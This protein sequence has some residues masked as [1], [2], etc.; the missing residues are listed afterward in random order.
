MR[1]FIC[2]SLALLVF[3]APARA[4]LEI[5]P[6]APAGAAVKDAA[7]AGERIVFA[8]TD[9]A[10]W[11]TDGR[12]VAKLREGLDP[13]ELSSAGETAYFTG[14]DDTLH[15]TDGTAVEPIKTGIVHTSFAGLAPIGPAYVFLAR[16]V[17]DTESNT[18]WRTDGS[19]AGTR[20]LGIYTWAWLPEVAAVGET[21]LLVKTRYFLYRTDGTTAVEE[22]A[23][24]DAATIPGGFLTRGPGP[25]GR[26]ELFRLDASGTNP[27]PVAPIEAP[28]WFARLT[29]RVIFQGDTSS[30]EPRWYSTDLTG[31]DVRTLPTLQATTPPHVAAGA[32]YLIHY[33]N[34]EAVLSRTDG[35]DVVVL[36]RFATAPSGFTAFEGR[37]WFAAGELWSTDGTAAGTRVEAPAA[38]PE[39]V[40]TD[41]VL[42]FTANGRPWVV[43]D[44]TVPTPTPTP[45]PTVTA[46]ATPTP[47][48]TATATPTATAT[49][50][51]TATAAPTATPVPTPVPLPAPARPPA[52]GT[53]PRAPSSQPKPSVT[54]AVKR[55]RSVRGATRWRVTGRLQATGC[56]GRVR[57]ELARVKTVTA[58]V[59]RCRYS[60]VVS[61]RRT[62]RW[63]VVRTV[64]TARLDAV[65][66]ATVRVP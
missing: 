24:R 22:G 49:A 36:G 29:G 34:G 32:A 1:V 18:L 63:V 44:E 30:S 53:H 64:P 62:V 4:Q 47:T 65:R 51:P 54:A 28:R 66:S 10:L 8:T 40:A 52:P 27:Q 9:G 46:T 33:E 11:S 23:T 38:G 15:R 60:A 41:D 21:T 2:L 56:T 5:A 17:G 39:L 14:A 45:T 13:H 3:A 7:R 26:Q 43:R 59:R 61:S 25:D 31:T 35:T 12:A 48:A 58:P 50:T 55:L 6:L 42:L 16:P 37:V 19:T 20:S 57:V